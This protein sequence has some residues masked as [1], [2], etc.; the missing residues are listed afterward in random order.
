VEHPALFAMPDGGHARC[1][2]PLNVEPVQ[3]TT[4]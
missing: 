2:Y 4:A 3:E 1:M